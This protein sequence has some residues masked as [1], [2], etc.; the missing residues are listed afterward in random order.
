MLTVGDKELEN[1]TVSIRTRDNVVHGEMPLD[2]FLASI[3][4]EMRERALKSSLTEK[5]HVGH[6]DQ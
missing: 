4:T 1:K 6:N 5:A 3:E 2:V